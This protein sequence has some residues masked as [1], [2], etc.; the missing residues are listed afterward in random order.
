MLTAPSG[1]CWLLSEII[2]RVLNNETPSFRPQ[3]T[4]YSGDDWRTRLD[5]H[6]LVAL[7]EDCW[8][9]DAATRPNISTVRSRF[10]AVN[11]GKSA[12]TH[13]H[14]SH[15]QYYSLTAHAVIVRHRAVAPQSTIMHPRFLRYRLSKSACA[16]VAKSDYMERHADG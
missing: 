15:Q 12:Y 7:I 1:E 2:S 16:K 13:T 11:S 14:T 3:L 5:Y 9:Q 6:R 10:N 8:S 4:S